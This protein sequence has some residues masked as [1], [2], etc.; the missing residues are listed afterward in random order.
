MSNPAHSGLL[1][2]GSIVLVGRVYQT[3]QQTGQDNFIIEKL[4]DREFQNTYYNK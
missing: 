2:R 4:I 3:I 1:A